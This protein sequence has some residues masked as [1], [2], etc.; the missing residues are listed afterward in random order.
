MYL[1]ITAVVSWNGV[2]SDQFKLWNGVKQEG[3]DQSSTFLYV[4]N[5]LLQDLNK[6]K[7]GCYMGDICSNFLL[8]LTV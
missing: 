1:I 5:P 7:I 4:Q 3:C 6:S 8:M 2:N